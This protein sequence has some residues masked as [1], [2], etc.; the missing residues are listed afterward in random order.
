MEPERLLEG[1]SNHYSH[2]RSVV[3]SSRLLEYTLEDGWEPLCQYLG[4]P[5]P[6]VPYPHENVGSYTADMHLEIMYFRLFK[7]GGKW[8]ALAAAGIA[9]LL[10]IWWKWQR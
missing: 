4:K 7:V 6:N 1:Y 9:A 2:I 10:A 5:V 8:A 3:P